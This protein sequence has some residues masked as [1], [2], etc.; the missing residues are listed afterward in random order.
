[1]LPDVALLNARPGM[2]WSMPLLVPSIGTR[3]TAVQLVPVAFS[4]CAITMSLVRHA[5][6]ARG[7]CIARV[8]N[9]RVEL[10]VRKEDLA[11]E[12]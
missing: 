3:L 11:A 7:D 9:G 4:E 5:R 12:D 2:K 10:N 1:M 6:Y 8:D